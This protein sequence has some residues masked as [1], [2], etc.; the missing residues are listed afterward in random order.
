MGLYGTVGKMEMLEVTDRNL[1][2]LERNRKGRILKK[3]WTSTCK[4]CVI[5][6]DEQ[7]LGKGTERPIEGTVKYLRE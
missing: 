7:E 6:V 5:L 4:G 3:K 1:N 2:I